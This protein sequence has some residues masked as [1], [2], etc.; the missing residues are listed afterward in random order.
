MATRLQERKFIKNSPDPQ[1]HAAHRVLGNPHR[2]LG[3]LSEQ[4]VMRIRSSGPRTF[5]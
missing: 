4:P 1:G 3:F 5:S 2:K